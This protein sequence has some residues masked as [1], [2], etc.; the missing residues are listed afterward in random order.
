MILLVIVVTQTFKVLKPDRLRRTFRRIFD[1][2]NTAR[3]LFINLRFG[4][5]LFLGSCFASFRFFAF[6]LLDLLSLLF[7]WTV[8]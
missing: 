4:W 8:L 2:F 1:P 3:L 7:C 6:L 5:T